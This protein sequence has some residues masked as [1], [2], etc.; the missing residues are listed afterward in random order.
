MGGSLLRVWLVAVAVGV[1]AAFGGGGSSWLR[2]ALVGTALGCALALVRRHPAVVLLALIL[3]GFACGAG[4]AGAQRRSSAAAV[5]A[6][7]VPGC[8]VTGRIL[9]SWGGLGTALA[10]DLL[11]CEG[12]PAVRDPGP[13][14]ADLVAHP[15]STFVATGWLIPLGD[16]HFDRAR[17]RAGA[18]AELALT[19]IELSPPRGLH[20]VAAAVREGLVEAASTVAP[21]EAGLIRGLTIGDTE[22]IAAPTLQSFRRSG[23][24]H[25]LA[26]SGSNVSIVLGAVMLVGARLPFRLRLIGGV[27]ALGLFVLVVGPD[28]SVL[29][30]AAMGAIGL[31]AL[32]TGRRS[33][34][35]H[36]LATA[37]AVVIAARPP[38]VF[39]VG[40]HLSVLATAGIIL[41][42]PIALDRFR[43]MPRPLALPLAVTIGAQAA[44]VPLLAVVF[45]EMSL[46]APAANLLA[47]VAVAPATILGLAGGVVA[48][49]HAGAGGLFLRAAEPF[50]SWILAVGELAGEPSWASVQVSAALGLVLTIPLTAIFGWAL[51][52]HT[53]GLPSRP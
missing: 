53:R 45:E 32:A 11:A 34:S 35:L 14:V 39:S 22:G 1:G 26:V 44:V 20:S 38:I 42:A 29:R 4:A 12:H 5:L 18:T 48:V 52:R 40:L 16:D 37:V 6:G 15:G 25:L 2:F 43:W 27:A 23:L 41:L 28:A 8:R 9:E 51:R 24:S 17:T 10:P 47:A 36:V 7:D 3:F 30:A 31:V 21:P 33:E 13:I 49:V 46:I 50:A 19:T